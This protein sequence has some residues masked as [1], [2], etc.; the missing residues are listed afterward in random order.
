MR[1]LRLPQNLIHKHMTLHHVHDF[2]CFNVKYP[3]SVKKMKINIFIYVNKNNSNCEHN[4]YCPNAC[5]K[6]MHA[7]KS[8][9]LF[10]YKAKLC[11]FFFSS[12]QFILTCKPHQQ[13]C[14]TLMKTWLRFVWVERSFEDVLRDRI[15]VTTDF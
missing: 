6:S 10:G 8:K 11:S 9:Q 1:I 13:V 12:Q 2:C 5:M 7:I 15:W 14:R 3:S 4:P